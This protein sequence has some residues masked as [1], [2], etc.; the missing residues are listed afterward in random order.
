MDKLLMRDIIANNVVREIGTQANRVVSILIGSGKEIDAATYIADME[1][2]ERHK[3]FYVNMSGMKRKKLFKKHIA[4]VNSLLGEVSLS[5]AIGQDKI[6]WIKDRIKAACLVAEG[7]D[8]YTHG[9]KPKKERFYGDRGS[10]LSRSESRLAQGNHITQQGDNKEVGTSHNTEQG[11]IKGAGRY[12]STKQGWVRP[13]TDMDDYYYLDKQE[14]AGVM[15]GRICP[16]C[17]ERLYFMSAN[18]ISHKYLCSE[19]GRDVVVL[20]EGVKTIDEGEE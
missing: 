5:D 14:I 3:Q 6:A 10:T 13:L 4:T 9:E 11:D 2:P 17:G 19:C 12:R 7:V 16:I 15:I 1:D 20:A 18:D 8:V